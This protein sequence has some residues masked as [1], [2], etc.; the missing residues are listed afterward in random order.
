MLLIYSFIIPSSL[1]PIEEKLEI[2]QLMKK[3]SRLVISQ[4][5]GEHYVFEKTQERENSGLRTFNLYGY[6]LAEQH[7]EC[8]RNLDILLSLDILSLGEI[9]KV[10]RVKNSF[11]LYEITF[12]S[13]YRSMKN[14]DNQIL[15]EQLSLKALKGIN[16]G[17]KHYEIRK[18]ILKLLRLEKDGYFNDLLRW[19]KL[20][21]LSF[22]I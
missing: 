10:L 17:K 11:D 14:L 12:E 9:M 19:L 18:E 15:I 21:L 3:V 2:S 5:I 13:K 1:S 8:E 20:K 16:L 22:T 6:P 4:N 7:F